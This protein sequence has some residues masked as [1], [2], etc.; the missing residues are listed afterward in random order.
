M[1]AWDKVCTPKSVGGLNLINIRL[2]NKVTIAKTN[3]DLAR[4][5]DKL[6]IRWKHTYYIKKSSTATV[7]IPTQASW[8]MKKI[9]AARATMNC[10]QLSNPVRSRT[11]YHN[12]LGEN[13]RGLW[14][15]PMF[16]NDA[17][18]KAKFTLWL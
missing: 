18:P 3:W 10:I 1:V 12:L 11:I 4:K 13:S 16:G 7:N 14:K 8:M 5:Q 9:I 6:W 17:R 15:A 2:W